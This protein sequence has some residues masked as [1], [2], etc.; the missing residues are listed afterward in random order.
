MFTSKVGSRPNELIL[1]YSIALAALAVVEQEFSV[2][3]ASIDP[4]IKTCIY[5]IQCAEDI[6]SLE[7]KQSTLAASFDPAKH[8]FT[9]DSH[10][11]YECGEGKAFGTL[12]SPIQQ[13]NFTCQWDGNWAPTDKLPSCIC[14]KTL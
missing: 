4:F 3:Y 7:E 6:A 12:A 8:N 13:T 11:V 9:Y 14:K 10:V 5:D 2:E 1:T